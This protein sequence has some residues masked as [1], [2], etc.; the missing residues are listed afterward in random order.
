MLVVIERLV[1]ESPRSL[2]GDEFPRY[3]KGYDV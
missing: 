3:F 1:R 2:P